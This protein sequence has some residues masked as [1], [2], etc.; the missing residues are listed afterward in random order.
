[1]LMEYVPL[2]LKAVLALFITFVLP[3]LLV[4]RVIKIDELPQRWLAVFLS[5]IAVN[6]LAVITIA[7]FGAKPTVFYGGMV[8]CIVVG[9]IVLEL[10]QPKFSY[11]LSE[12]RL[13][14]AFWLLFSLI[15][16]GAIYSDIWR[17]GI[18]SSFDDGDVSIAWN[19]WALAWASGQFA[20]ESGGYPQFM[21]TIWAVAYLVTG[22]QVQYFAFYS[23]LVLI[24]APLVLSAM[25]LGR[26]RWWLPL[27]QL[28]VFACFITGIVALG[29]RST[30]P[31]AYSDWVVIAFAFAG[32]ALFLSQRP[33]HQRS[34]TVLLLALFLECVAAASKPIYGLFVV[35][36]ALAICVDVFRNTEDRT[37][38]TRVILTIV[39]IVSLFA[40]AYWI[41]L[42]HL[43][44]YG[45]AHPVWRPAYNWEQFS[46]SFSRP[47][48][49]LCFAGL[50]LSLILP[51][52]RWLAL[53]LFVGF[54][55]WAYFASYDVRNCM[56]LVLIA[57]LIPI[58]ALVRRFIPGDAGAFG[59][60]WIVGDKTV[61][62]C[63]LIALLLF[64][65][66]MAKSDQ[67]LEAQFT[68]EQLR[69]GPGPVHNEAITKHLHAGCTL[70]TTTK[71]PWTM[72]SLQ[73]YKPQTRYFYY[74]LPIGDDDSANDR[75]RKYG[76][77]LQRDFENVQGCAAVIFPPAL[78]H[79]KAL[80]FLR[81]YLQRRNFKKVVDTN[82][83][84]FWS[85]Q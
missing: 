39:G 51:R 54:G 27:V 37:L 7:L 6:H 78:Q 68:A 20:L 53:P 42:S 15:A 23:Y 36:F 60:T 19:A 33:P 61:A 75:V 12:I 43:P 64:T 28:S 41:N 62:A 56:G 55:I 47:L 26:L 57:A 70:F 24:V 50:F 1:M 2:Y 67:Q 76:V 59:R 58:E 84:E 45:L 30:L 48:R 9:L 32:A 63:A 21:P 8:L 79:P 72:V 44:R 22:S 35:A 13:S 4:V 46:G 85:N 18:P 3:G 14:D 73:S 82:G 38:R 69:L 34:F 81:D 10:R 66:P 71:Y 52:A 25:V 17:H 65:L 83:M 40:L 29:V 31:A 49:I 11:A 16:L 5:S 80:T 74:A 77:D